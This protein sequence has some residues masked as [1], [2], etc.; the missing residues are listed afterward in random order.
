MLALNPIDFSSQFFLAGVVHIF[1]NVN[2]FYGTWV[3]RVFISY[4][5]I[6]LIYFVTTILLTEVRVIFS[7]LFNRKLNCKCLCTVKYYRCFT[8]G[9]HTRFYAINWGLW[10]K[11]CYGTFRYGVGYENQEALAYMSPLLHSVQTLWQM[12][13]KWR[14]Q[15]HHFRGKMYSQWRELRTCDTQHRVPHSPDLWRW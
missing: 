1:C 7:E 10:C 8:P 12:S 13:E 9:G 4:V 5:T 15:S 2:N 3:F 14:Q 6:K 11:I